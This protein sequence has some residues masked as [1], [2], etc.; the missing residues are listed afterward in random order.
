M[1]RIG[2]TMLG[3]HRD[4]AHFFRAGWKKRVIL[5]CWI[6]QVGILLGLMGLFSWRLSRTVATWKEAEE[7]GDIPVVEFVW[8][9][10]NITF[11]LSS[12]AVTCVSIA[13]FIAEVLTPLPLLFGCIL[14]LVLSAS[15]LAL[16]IV[17]Y[18]RRADKKYSIIGLGLDVT[19]IVFTIIPL[20]Y[21]ILIYRRLLTYDDYHLPGNHKPYGFANAEEEMSDD[22]FAA[23]PSSSSLPSIYLSAPTAYYDPTK[24]NNGELGT[25]TTVTA[26]PPADTSRGRSLSFGSR[27]ISLSLSLSRGESNASPPSPP[28]LDPSPVVDQRRTSY[29][30]K[31]DTQFETYLARRTSQ[32]YDRDSRHSD[33]LSYEDVKRSLDNEFG[34][35]AKRTILTTEGTVQAAHHVPR[36]ARASSI[37]LARQT[38]YEVVVGGAPT[39]PLDS[40]ITRRS[41]TGPNS[42]PVVVTTPPPE[43]EQ[44]GHSLNCVPEAHD[45][46]EEQQHVS[47]N[48]F[49]SSSYAQRRRAKSESEQALL[50]GGSE[51]KDDE[52]RR[53]PGGPALV[54]QVVGGGLEDIDIGVEGGEAESRK[55]RRDS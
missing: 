17:V 23:A 3:S 24:N 53:A 47:S 42:L 26:V 30:H 15:V 8:E 43:D 12:L 22:P 16:D 49:S 10:A 33:I 37:P 25:V 54:K 7:K 20:I 14:N 32:T 9:A 35:I 40:G 13:R 19:L 4:N 55:R 1:L 27:R 36:V 11:S 2:P 52:N 6:V 31:R 45:E 34:F 44:L 51:K 28:T 29:D 46:E 38:S 39:P 18:I 21:A 5:P 41:S 48:S 50:G